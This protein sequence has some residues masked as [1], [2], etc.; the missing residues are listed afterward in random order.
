LYR[1]RL[2]CPRFQAACPIRRK[3]IHVADL[4]FVA[5]AIVAFCVVAVILRGVARL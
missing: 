5:L 3:G 4:I 1:C 2:A